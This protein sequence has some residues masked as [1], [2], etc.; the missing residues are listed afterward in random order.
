MGAE[1][2]QP[3]LG[4]LQP[5]FDDFM[6][7]FEPLQGMNQLVKG[8]QYLSPFFRTIFQLKKYVNSSDISRGNKCRNHAIEWY[9]TGLKDE[10]I[11]QL[12]E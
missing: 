4:Q 12:Y 11:G 8:I 10:S 9:G 6:D 1:F 5:N 3:G 7:T 2:M